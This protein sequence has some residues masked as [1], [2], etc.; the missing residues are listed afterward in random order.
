LGKAKEQL[1]SEGWDIVAKELQ[2]ILSAAVGIPTFIVGFN[3]R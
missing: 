3:L 1:E 2:S